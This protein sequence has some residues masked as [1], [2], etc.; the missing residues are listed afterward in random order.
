MII[1]YGFLPGRRSGVGRGRILHTQAEILAGFLTLPVTPLLQGPVKGHSSGEFAGIDATAT[2]PA[3]L[4]MQY[5]RWF[6]FLRVGY[7]HVYLAYLHALVAAVA[8]IRIEYYRCIR[9]GY[10]WHS[11]YFFLSHNNLLCSGLPILLFTC[12]LIQ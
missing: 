9:G 7:V 3:F 6:A 8:Y 11:I 5:N 12:Q 4:R 1:I 2:V 10:I